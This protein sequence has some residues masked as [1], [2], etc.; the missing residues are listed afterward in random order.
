VEA[1][2]FSEQKGKANKTYSLLLMLDTLQIDTFG[3]KVLLCAIFSVKEHTKLKSAKSIK[4]KSATAF[5]LSAYV[6]SYKHG[7]G[8]N[9][10][11]YV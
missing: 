1:V 7:D 3:S 9:L 8:A 10:Q 2:T 6:N 4:T 11:G 5:G